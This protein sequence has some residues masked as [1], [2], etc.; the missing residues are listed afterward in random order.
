MLVKYFFFLNQKRDRKRSHFH[1]ALPEWIYF[2]FPKQQTIAL[3]PSYWTFYAGFMYIQ[4]IT[5]RDCS[6][7]KSLTK[8]TCE[9]WSVDCSIFW[10]HILTCLREN[11]D[12]VSTSV[13]WRWFKKK[14][15]SLKEPHYPKKHKTQIREKP[16]SNWTSTRNS[17]Y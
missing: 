14:K 11:W 15:K 2:L 1:R 4:I 9:V 3:N 17:A 5:I 10:A 12:G 13:T 16:V 6:Q 8:H 7:I